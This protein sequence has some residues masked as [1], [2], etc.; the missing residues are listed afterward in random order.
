MLE[1]RVGLQ[2]AQQIGR[3]NLKLLVPLAQQ[4]GQK[5]LHG[6][7]G[8]DLVGQYGRNAL[9]A[10]R[11]HKTTVFTVTLLTD[12]LSLVDPGVSLLHP[13]GALGGDDEPGKIPLCFH[14]FVL[15]FTLGYNFREVRHL[16]ENLKAMYHSPYAVT[17]KSPEKN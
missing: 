11:I 7:P 15:F 1:A 5:R 9:F 14:S 13:S 17:A 3:Q 6:G 2:L 10:D 12:D 4:L 8:G 16:V